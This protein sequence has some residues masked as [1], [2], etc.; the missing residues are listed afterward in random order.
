MRSL[1][2]ILHTMIGY[3]LKL[4][5]LRVERKRNKLMSLRVDYDKLLERYKTFGPR[6]KTYKILNCIL[7]QSMMIDI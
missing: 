4:S 2:L 6:M 1:V 7:Y 5:K 3:I